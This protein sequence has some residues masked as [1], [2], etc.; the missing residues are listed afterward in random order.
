[1]K[2]TLKRFVVVFCFEM[3]PC[4]VTQAGMQWH[5]LGSLQPPSPGLKQFSCLS[6]WSSWDYGHVLPCPANFCVF[7]RDWV[8]PGR[9]GW[10]WTPDLRWST[11]LGSQSAGITGVSHWAWLSN[12]LN[13]LSLICLVA[14]K[15]LLLWKLKDDPSFRCV[16]SSLLPLLVITGFL[17]LSEE[18][19]L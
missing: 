18:G 14:T 10:S 17:C 12:N 13:I 3:K 11:H 2:G 8:S 1:M 19:A 6:F 9:P 16:F 5:D 7:S 4:S 15:I